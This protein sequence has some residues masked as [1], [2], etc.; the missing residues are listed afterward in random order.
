MICGITTCH[1]VILI[2]TENDLIRYRP[3]MLRRMGLFPTL[4]Y[5]DTRGRGR[6]MLRHT[7]QVFV[8][9]TVRF[10]LGEVRF[11]VQQTS[12]LSGSYVVRSVKPTSTSILTEEGQGGCIRRLGWE[13]VLVSIVEGWAFL[14]TKL[15]VV[16][17]LPCT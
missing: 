3:N 5:Y 16:C 6:V 14:D 1:A 2:A 15:V 10:L 9:T 8:M 7:P 13:D 17:T 4:C 12:S 11:V